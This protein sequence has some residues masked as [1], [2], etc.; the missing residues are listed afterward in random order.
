MLERN[1]HPSPPIAVV[2]EE[3]DSIPVITITGELDISTAPAVRGILTTAT[4]APAPRLIIDLTGLTFCGSA[5]IAELLTARERLLGHSPAAD[6]VLA[7]C[8]TGVRRLLLFAGVRELFR[9]TATMAE[10]ILSP[11]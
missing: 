10:A 6:V 2:A 4:A 9:L 11:A 8:Q 7:G 5:G 3:I 1:G